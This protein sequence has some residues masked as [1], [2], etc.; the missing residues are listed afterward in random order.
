ASSPCGAQW[1]TRTLAALAATLC[2]L[3]PKQLCWLSRGDGMKFLVPR[4]AGP[5]HRV[6]DAKQL[7]RASSERNLL[8]LAGC[9]QA[10][11]ERF[12]DR[13]ETHRTEYGHM[14]RAA[15]DTASAPD[16]TFA[17]FL[18][19]VPIQRRHAGQLGRA[20]ITDCSQFGHEGQQRGA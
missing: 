13:V 10:L 14:Q 12:D 11:V 19:G 17:A 4:L 2:P 18:A 1:P 3:P 16:V 9:D 7:V 20:R 8:G 15:H 5:R 6:E